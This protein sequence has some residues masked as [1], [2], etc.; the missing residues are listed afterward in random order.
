[1]AANHTKPGTALKE[2]E[3]LYMYIY[4]HLFCLLSASII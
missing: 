1:M 4:T 2:T 3:V